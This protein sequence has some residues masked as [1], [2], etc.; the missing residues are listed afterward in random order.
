MQDH[1]DE[2]VDL[3]VENID[4]TKETAETFVKSPHMKYDTDPFTNS[5]SKMW[6]KM[7]AF[8][9][10]EKGDVDLNKHLNDKF[11]KKHSTHSLKTIQTAISSKASSLS[12]KRT[13]PFWATFNQ[14]NVRLGGLF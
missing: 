6:D 13:T 10:L 4:V 7:V 8:K 14:E 3:V 2:V 5:V 1:K 11:M 12:L 9:Y